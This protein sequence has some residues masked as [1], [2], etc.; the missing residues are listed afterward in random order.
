MEALAGYITLIVII[1]FIYQ[2]FF[3]KKNNFKINYKGRFF[4]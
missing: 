3:N 2:T 1:G 4:R